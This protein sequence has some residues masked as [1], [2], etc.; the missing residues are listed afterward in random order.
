MGKMKMSSSGVES[1][2]ES[3][4]LAVIELLKP[5]IKE[6]E[7]IIEIPKPVLKEVDFPVE[8][9]KV[10]EVEF[11]INKP[12]Y[13]VS[14]VEYNV[15]KPVIKIT[16]YEEFVIKPVFNIKQELIVL[17]EFQQELE[18]SLNVSRAKV[19]EFNKIVA[20]KAEMDSNIVKKI[21]AGVKTLK[22]SL[23]FVGI[24]SLLTLA[25]VFLR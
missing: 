5:T 24:L 7:M 21:E 8:I 18:K 2:P 23:L 10:R 17:D 9:P 22:I 25:A 3:S 6:V 1:T 13:N 4:E 12:I 19:D 11:A 15:E 16:E 14:R 20:E